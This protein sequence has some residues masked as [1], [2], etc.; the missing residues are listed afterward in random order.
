MLEVFHLYDKERRSRWLLNLMT[1]YFRPSKSWKSFPNIRSKWANR[2]SYLNREFQDTMTS[3][4]NSV[5]IYERKPPYVG[6]RSTD[7]N[8]WQANQKYINVIRPPSRRRYPDRTS[9][10]PVSRHPTF[11]RKQKRPKTYTK[12][13]A[14]SD[15]SPFKRHRTSVVKKSKA[16]KR[17]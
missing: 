8:T 12:N 6:R 14:K 17:N 16:K 7:D 13:S 3:N 9:F 5:N 10:D 2:F 11:D 1:S 4:I 15:G